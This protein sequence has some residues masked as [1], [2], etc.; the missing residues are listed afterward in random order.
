VTKYVIHP[1]AQPLPAPPPTTGDLQAKRQA[2]FNAGLSTFVLSFL[3]L[4]IVAALAGARALRTYAIIA[5]I[6]ALASIALTAYLLI[7]W[8]VNVASRDWRVDD[9]ERDRRWRHEDEDRKWARQQAETTQE[10]AAPAPDLAWVHRLALAILQRH[11]AGQPTTRAAC[12]KAGLC[13]QAQ[14]NALNRVFQVASF[15]R[16]NTLDPGPDLAAAQANW[17][18][19][20]EIDRADILVWR[21]PDHRRG[22]EVISVDP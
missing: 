17:F 5:A 19:Q 10:D 21:S 12:T 18:R 15:K 11:Y 3:G 4:A 16:K 22:A 9:K 14:W 6:C 7:R 20:V 2:A 1:G 8:A 13:T